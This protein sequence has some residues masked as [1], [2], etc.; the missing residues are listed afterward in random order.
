M[1]LAEA[2]ITSMAKWARKPADLYETPP[3]VTQALVLANPPPVGA[4][5]WEPFCATGKISK[6]LMYHGYQVA[7]TDLRH[8]G[9]GV[10]GVDFLQTQPDP[11]TPIDGIASNPPFSIAA[12]C[13]SHAL[14][15]LEVRY[16]A[17]LLKSNFWHTKGRMS[18]KE[19]HP[20]TAEHPVSWRIPFLEKERGKSPLMDCTWFVWDKS[21]DRIRTEVL[22]RPATFPDVDDPGMRCRIF[23]NREAHERLRALLS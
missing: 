6:V 10:G 14:D 16:L 17:L 19:R 13:I 23:A 11:D 7:S 18:L 2:T 20:P 5:L 4:R 9:F 12:E 3:S 21:Q 8:T 15:V 1:G 22:P